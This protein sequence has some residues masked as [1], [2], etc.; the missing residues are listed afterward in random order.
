MRDGTVEL[1]LGH[2]INIKR[3][4]SKANGVY[5][6]QILDILDDEIIIVSGP[7]HKRNI[8]LLNKDEIVEVSY[9]IED[10]G[11]Y[12]FRA[13]VLDRDNSKIYRLKLKR[14]S[15]V[16]RVQ[17]RRFYRLEVDVP[18]KKEFV[19][20]EDGERR[21]IEENCRSQNISGGGIK[22]YSNYEHKIGDQVLCS[23]FINNHQ[24]VATGKVVRIEEVDIFYYKY[25]I[26]VKFVEL[27]E[28]D[29][30]RIISFIFHKQRELRNKGLI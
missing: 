17:L 12:F 7:L 20:E 29:R 5:P 10:K 9:I 13:K 1:S 14:I 2:K 18:V 4:K 26:G 30:D 8:V 24:I 25:G 28:E 16:N 6:S 19:I 3:I 11:K 21:V 15:D 23:F 27:N 22:L